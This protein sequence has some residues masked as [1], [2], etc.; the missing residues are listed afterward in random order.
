MTSERYYGYG[1]GTA[2]YRA[3]YSSRRAPAGRTLYRAQPGSTSRAAGNRLSPNPRNSADRA[4][5]Q[6]ARGD[7]RRPSNPGSRRPDENRPPRPPRRKRGLMRIP[8]K[9]RLALCVLCVALVAFGA[10]KLIAVTRSNAEERF[11]DNVYVNGVCLT[12][13]TKDEGFQKMHDLRDNWLNTTYHLTFNGQTWD[14]SPASVNASLEFDTELEHAWNLGHVGDRATRREIVNGL[15][16]LPAEFYSEPTYDE[17][18][19]DAFVEKV[20][21][22]INLDPIDAEVTL[23]ELKPVITRPSVNGYKLDE[24]KLRENLVNIIMTGEGDLELPVDVV[25][26]TV[27]SDNMEMTMIAKFETDVSFR[28]Y[29]SRSN[30][31]L[32]LNHFN[33][34]AVYPG[35]T[36]S[37]NEVVGPRTE[38]AGFKSAPEYAGDNTEMGIGGGVC[39]AS[40]TLYNAVIQAGMTIIQRNRHTMTVTYVDPSLD[41]AVNY[42][43]KDLVFRNDTPHAIYIYTDVSAEVAKVIIYGTRPEY[44]YELESVVLHEEPSTKIGYQDDV[45]GKHVYYSSDA[46]VLYKEG[47][48]S[49]ESEGWIVSYDWETKQEVSRVQVNHD[50]YS[51]GVNV[52]WR[53]VHEKKQ[54]S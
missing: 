53:G 49:C 52:Y 45:D 6:D 12:G 26:P 27:V 36:V 33:L 9:V 54:A 25:Q 24:D 48:G 31:R 11:V 46:P 34:F 14:F 13:Y 29:P 38:T 4:R 28:G 22:D 3:G 17:A 1:S 19:L 16:Q 30:V 15:K 44:H 7:M 32:A 39:Q 5:R 21:G 42:G 18:A 47:R 40:T 41:A 51:A 35:Q 8:A 2:A 20:A 37:F 10:V 50:I 23:T 43:E